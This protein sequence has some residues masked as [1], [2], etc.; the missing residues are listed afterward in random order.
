[1]EENS[2]E[3]VETIAS[4]KAV[5]NKKS[6]KQFAILSAIGIVMVVSGH[7]GNKLNLFTEIFPYNSFFMPL[8]VFISGYFFKDKSTENIWLYIK[9]KCKNLLLYYF[10]WNILYGLIEWAIYLSGV[11]EGTPEPATFSIYTIFRRP[12]IDGQQ[13]GLFTPTWF[14]PMLFTVEITFLIIRKLQIKIGHNVEYVFLIMFIF[15]NIISVYISK[16]FKVNH[17]F[18]PFLKIGFF[19][20]FFQL[21]KLY[22]DKFEKMENKIPSIIVILTTFF[23]NLIMIKLYKDISFSSLYNMGNFVNRPSF[24]PVIVAVTG[25][26]FWLRISKILVPAIGK[27][28]IVDNI[29]NHTKEIMTHHILGIYLCHFV[30]YLLRNV[31]N[32]QGFQAINFARS[33]G[34]YRYYADTDQIGIVYIIIGIF[35]PLLLVKIKEIIKANIETAKNKFNNLQKN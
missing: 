10:I 27:N 35:F 25:I 15:L 6:N 7:V 12:F 16:N 29:S 19:I 20:L 23:I 31:L 28:K 5:E 22:K 17:N 11:I 34:W 26:W 4:K 14:I 18:Y 33:W 9:K 21:G 8:F 13:W 24:L 3:N 30:L 32:L 2:I 1:M